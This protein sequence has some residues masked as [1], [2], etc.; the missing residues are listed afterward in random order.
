M[1]YLIRHFTDYSYEQPVEQAHNQLRML[2]R[3]TPTQ[4]CLSYGV[5]VTPKPR[6]S[7]LHRD[8]LGNKF[9]YLEADKP[10][11]RFKIFVRHDVDVLPPPAV[12]PVQTPAWESL[13]D[14]HRSGSLDESEA[15]HGFASTLIPINPTLA[16]LAKPHFT[17]GRPVLD[18]ALALNTAIHQDFAFD[19][20]ATSVASPVHEVLRG[21]RGVCQDF[22]HVMI[23]ALR[24]IGLVARYVSGY[25]ETLPPPG[26]PRLVG[27]DASHAWVSLW[28]GPE[29]SWQ[30]LDPTNNSQPSGQHITTAWGRDYNDV[31]PLNG[32]VDGG[33]GKTTLKIR[34]DVM[35]QESPHPESLGD[36]D[37]SQRER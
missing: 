7:R 6:W 32:V 8:V 19:P 21:R 34:V 1:R 31:T 26:K 14:L 5:R 15:M 17:P 18:A 24:S 27:A 10:H 13:R 12:D 23:A 22:S 16:A 25:I 29:A 2:L 36:S 9:L 4:H 33:E 11:T 3:D 37:L 20:Q 30:D 35:R 28:C